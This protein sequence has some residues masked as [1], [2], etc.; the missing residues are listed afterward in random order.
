[1]WCILLYKKNEKFSH[2]FIAAIHSAIFRPIKGDPRYY[3]HNEYI[4]GISRSISRERNSTA[5]C[6]RSDL[7]KGGQTLVSLPLLSVARAI[8]GVTPRKFQSIKKKHLHESREYEHAFMFLGIY[9][10]AF[11]SFMFT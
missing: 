10:I 9:S 5:F 6:H 11:R 1:M 3:F 8:S 4:R 2:P 7:E